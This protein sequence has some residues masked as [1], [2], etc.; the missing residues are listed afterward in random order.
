MRAV[1]AHRQMHSDPRDRGGSSKLGSLSSF[2]LFPFKKKEEIPS[3]AGG[4]GSISSSKSGVSITVDK[5]DYFLNEAM[6]RQLRVTDPTFK[7]KPGQS[8]QVNL[9]NSSIS[10]LARDGQISSIKKS[11]MTSSEVKV[12]SQRDRV[13]ESMLL[14]QQQLSQ[15]HQPPSSARSVNSSGT[16]T[17]SAQSS[18]SRGSGKH[19]KVAAA[20]K[21]KISNGSAPSQSSPESILAALNKIRT[22]SVAP[23]VST[24]DNARTPS[25]TPQSSNPSDDCD[26]GDK[27][28]KGEGSSA[29]A[30]AVKTAETKPLCCDK[31]DGKHETDLC[32][33]YKK[34]RENHPDAQRS[35]KHMGGLSRLPGSVL[36][37]GRVVR[38]PGDGSCLFHSLS[39]GLPSSSNASKLRSE[40]CSFIASNP[41]F[42]ISDTPLKDWV[43]WDSG[44]S[45]AEYSRRMSRG[46][47]G[48]GIEMACCSQI[49][50]VN[51]HVYERSGTQFKRIS[52]FDHPVSPETKPIVRV[53]YCG[54]VHYGE[55][56]IPA[57]LC[58][59][60]M[61]KSLSN[62]HFC[63]CISLSADALV[64]T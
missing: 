33:H 11:A 42:K 62:N 12:M 48:G 30:V 6:R 22:A 45:V 15:Y 46:S 9:S 40:I 56:C 59:V 23:T 1:Q 39:Y 41:N 43:K 18:G 53:L 7:K 32:P 4:L 3:Y 8:Q 24:L 60:S 26:D 36:R 34:K 25:V 16:A 21:S 31:C 57:M 27:S 35:K 55:Y 13:R 58:V 2:F 44:S 10:K 17:S 29:K 19:S 61:W 49:K 52:A 37:N 20:G 63:C 54:G 14:Q 51:V 28:E 50:G 47:W 64:A 5:G 38:Q